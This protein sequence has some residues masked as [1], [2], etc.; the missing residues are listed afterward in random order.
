MNTVV[1]I[2]KGNFHLDVRTMDGTLTLC[3]AQEQFVFRRQK[4]LSK[5]KGLSI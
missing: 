1:I 5:G 4:L 3:S 2:S